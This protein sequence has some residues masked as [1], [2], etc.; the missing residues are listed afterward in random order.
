MVIFIYFLFI[1]K[2][3]SNV[4]SFVLK[5]YKIRNKWCKEKNL[6]SEITKAKYHGLN[7]PV[8]RATPVFLY[9]VSLIEPTH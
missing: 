8:T 9:L 2:T 7:Y 3:W 5:G 1:S 4:Y 6:W